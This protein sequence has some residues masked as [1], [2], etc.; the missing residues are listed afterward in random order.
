[1]SLLRIRRAALLEFDNTVK[2]FFRAVTPY[3]AAII[4]VG[5]NVGIEKQSP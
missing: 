5:Q 4:Y 3:S 2:I 1:M